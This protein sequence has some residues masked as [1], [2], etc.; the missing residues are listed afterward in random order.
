METVTV[1]VTMLVQVIQTRHRRRRHHR[2]L[3][4]LDNCQDCSALEDP[5]DQDHLNLLQR[6]PCHVWQVIF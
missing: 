3:P 1:T 4:M 2:R 5:W 6:L